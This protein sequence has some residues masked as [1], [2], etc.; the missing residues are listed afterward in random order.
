MEILVDRHIR[1]DVLINGK[2]LSAASHA[3]HTALR[4]TYWTY[5]SI[6]QAKQHVYLLP[7]MRDLKG[8]NEATLFFK[9]LQLFTEVKTL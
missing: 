6:S 5:L 8:L 9:T 7:K 2:F 3:P 1:E 4:L